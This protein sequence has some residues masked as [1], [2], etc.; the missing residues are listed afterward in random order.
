M[1]K[2]RLNRLSGVSTVI[3][4]GGQEPE[5]EVRPDPAKM[6]QTAITVPALLDAIRRSNLIDSPGL[7]ESNH[8]LILSLVSGQARTAEEISH[9]AGDNRELVSQGGGLDEFPS[10]G[11]EEVAHRARSRAGSGPDFAK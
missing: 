3:V 7:V 1:T 2:P 11:V 4:Q 9:I 10:I 8:Q 5:F 6:L